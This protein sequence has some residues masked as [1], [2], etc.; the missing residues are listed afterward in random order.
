[1]TPFSHPLLVIIRLTSY[2]CHNRVATRLHPPLNIQVL[3]LSNRDESHV[4]S[5]VHRH[6]RIS[7]NNCFRLLYRKMAY[8]EFRKGVDAAVMT[9]HVTNVMDGVNI[10]LA[11]GTDL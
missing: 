8:D 6:G 3:T 11:K 5:R 1:M 4:V 2:L 10:I 9:G 7:Y